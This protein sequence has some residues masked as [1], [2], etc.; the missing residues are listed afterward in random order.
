MLLQFDN[1]PAIC[2]FGRIL[3]IHSKC[4]HLVDTGIDGFNNVRWDKSILYE[5]KTL[6][7]S[8]E[9]SFG[10]LDVFFR[11]FVTIHV[12]HIYS[13]VLGITCEAT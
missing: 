9:L 1:P 5:A 7:V 3:G 8:A 6:R 11:K 13:I 2:T 4:N 12:E 10:T